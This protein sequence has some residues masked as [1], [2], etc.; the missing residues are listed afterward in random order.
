M[1]SSSRCEITIF[2]LSM[3]FFPNF[4]AIF[5]KENV[6]SIMLALKGPGHVM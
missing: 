2:M 4:V 1:D 5:A 3:A 6:F